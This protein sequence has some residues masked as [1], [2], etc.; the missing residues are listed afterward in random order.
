MSKRKTTF[1]LIT[2]VIALIILFNFFGLLTPLK[3]G[4]FFLIDISVGRISGVGD[5]FLYKKELH[6]KKVDLVLENHQLEE[7][8]LQNQVDTTRLELLDEENKNLRAQLFFFEKF[9]S[10]HIGAQVVGRTID[11]L[12]TIIT[13]NKGSVDNVYIH[14]PVIISSG[15]LIGEVISTLPHASMVRLINDNTSKIGAMVI[16]GDKSIG[17]VEGG[18]GL[19]VHMNFIPQNEVVTPGD[20]IVTSGLTEGMPR[21]LII[22]KVEV[23]EKQPHEPFQQAILEPLADLSHLTTVSVI[24]SS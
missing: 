11:P 22:G 14:N 7:K 21:G 1:T 15:I 19:G 4:V 3:R 9:P 13:L 20:I 16:N 2:T 5:Y 6:Q 23:V 10:V 17:L 12:E 8:L 24:S 18:Y